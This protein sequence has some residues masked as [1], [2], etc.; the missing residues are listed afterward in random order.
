MSQYVD[1]WH[2]MTYDYSVSD[3]PNATLTAPN[4]PLYTPAD[5]RL[6][7]WSINDTGMSILLA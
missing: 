2:V 6:P 7:Q 5:P 4:C 3:L 1:Y